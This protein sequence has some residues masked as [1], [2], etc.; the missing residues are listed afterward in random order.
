VDE[1]RRFTQGRWDLPRRSSHVAQ[2]WSLD[3]VA[4]VQS[5]AS[6]I[7][8]VQKAFASRQR[9]PHFGNYK[10]C[11]E[12]AE[13]EEILRSHDIDSLSIE[14]V[15][16]AGSDPICYITPEGFAYYLPGLVRLALAEPVE[17]YGWYGSQ[18]V[19]HLCSDGRRNERVLACSVEQRRAI[20]AFLRHLVETRS[21]LADSYHC[22]DELFHAIDY[23]SDESDAV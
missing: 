19:S 16:T 11:D 14:D 5:D 22:S 18:L 4:F 7:Q 8:T 9:P 23:W 15:G 3:S 21:Q 2:L 6:I 12:C 1:R 13:Y 10:H 17:R 20:V